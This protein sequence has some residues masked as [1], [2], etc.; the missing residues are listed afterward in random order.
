MKLNTQ[1]FPY[2]V[3]TNDE[4]AAADYK[5]GAFQCSLL[6]SSEVNQDSKFDIEY[7]FIL[8]NE[9]IQAAVDTGDAS[10]ALDVSCSD[11]F[12]RKLF[13]LEGSGKLEMN[14]LEL[15]GKVEFTPIVVVKKSNVSFSS[16][17]LNDEFEGASF[18]LE[19]GD[20]IAVDDTWTK[21]IE[22][23]SLSFDTLVKVAT[24][25]QLQPFEYRIEPSPSFIYIWMGVKMRELWREMNQSR[26]HK[27]LIAMSIYK[28]LVFLAVEELVVNPD[29]ESQQWARTLRSK[30][31]AMGCELPKER[32]FNAINLIAQR[33]VSDGGVKKLTKDLGV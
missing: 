7:A 2:P 20:I 28:D 25:D 18:N 22:F 21:Y 26:K 5:D 13:F 15:Y 1:A 8:S 6:F 14:A 12:Y 29:A 32:E 27:P 10:F 31:E 30:I 19:F 24:D 23:N 4:G 17:D 3:L 16:D 33:L 9:D 11:T